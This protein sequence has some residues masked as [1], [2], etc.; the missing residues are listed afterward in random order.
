MG[1]TE[2]AVIVLRGKGSELDRAVLE[3]KS[4][5]GGDFSGAVVEFLQK[6]VLHPGDSITLEDCD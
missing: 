5:E 1:D 4:R 2:R 6:Q 3:I